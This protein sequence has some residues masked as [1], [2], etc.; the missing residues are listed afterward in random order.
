M[1]KQFTLAILALIVFTFIFGGLKNVTANSNKTLHGIYKCDGDTKY[2][3]ADDGTPQPCYFCFTSDHEVKYV[4]PQVTST[5]DSDDFWYGEVAV[6]TWKYAGEGN[7]KIKLSNVYDS[8][9]Y[10]QDAWFIKNKLRIRDTKDK[11]AYT[12]GDPI[13]S[14]KIDM[15]QS[16]FDEMFEEGKT[17]EK[18]GI[19]EDGPQKPYDYTHYDD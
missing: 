17:S 1:K 2:T 9:H 16:D 19:K 14:Y 18:K 10:E 5:N 4:C 11:P 15:S 13:N 12:L 3:D 8:G 6:G 7:F